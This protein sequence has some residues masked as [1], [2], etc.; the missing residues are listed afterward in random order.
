M[1][2][3]WNRVVI[4]RGFPLRASYSSPHAEGG[5]WARAM[6]EDFG[7]VGSVAAGAWQE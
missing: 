3:R 5:M 4:P 7:D 2:S 1:L 6:E